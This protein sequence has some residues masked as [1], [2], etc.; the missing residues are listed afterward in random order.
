MLNRVNG[1][2]VMKLAMFVDALLVCG[3]ATVWAK[4]GTVGYGFNPAVA[5]T[6][7]AG[8]FVVGF[9]P[10]DR[11]REDGSEASFLRRVLAAGKVATQELRFPGASLVTSPPA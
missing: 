8:G 9:E 10:L 3:R 5:F 6:D 4:P 2:W 11:Q 7:D 1:R